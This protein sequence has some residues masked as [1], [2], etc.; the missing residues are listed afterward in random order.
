MMVRVTASLRIRHEPFINPDDDRPTAHGEDD[1]VNETP[2]PRILLRVAP[3]LLG[4]VLSLALRDQGIDVVLDLG[5]GPVDPDRRFDVALVT[6]DLRGDVTADTVLVLDATGSTM[7]VEG[8]GHQREIT[9]G[10]E[11]P[12][13]LGLLEGLLA[14]RAL[15]GG[16]GEA[17]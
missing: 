9:L 10:S 3:R 15:D 16:L 7:R 4:D 8:E 2:S 1:R 12:E 13:L 17:R 11:L 5:D 6:D 14:D